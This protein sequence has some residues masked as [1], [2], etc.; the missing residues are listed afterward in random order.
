[1]FYSYLFSNYFVSCLG[2]EICS[3][4]IFVFF[5]VFGLSLG[6][7]IFVVVVEEKILLSDFRFLC[8]GRV[9]VFIEV[10]IRKLARKF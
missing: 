10:G 5:V 1:M 4:F 9:F 8:C 3:C 6:C 7:L 2:I